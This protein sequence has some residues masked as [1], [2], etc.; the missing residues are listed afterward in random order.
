[1]IDDK[2]TLTKTNI[3]HENNI[4]NI[5]LDD[6]KDQCVFKDLGIYFGELTVKDLNCE[7]IEEYINYVEPKHKI[8]MSVFVNKHLIPY[9][10]K[11][12]SEL[13]YTK[14]QNQ[15][16]NCTFKDGVFDGSFA[17]RSHSIYNYKIDISKLKSAFLENVRV[18]SKVKSIE[19]SSNGLYSS[20]LPFILN[21]LKDPEITNCLQDTIINLSDNKIEGLGE[22][23]NIVD[24][25]IKSIAEIDSIKYIIMT[26]NPFA[27]I[28]RKDFFET[29]DIN[30]IITKKIIWIRDYNITVFGWQMLVQSKEV[31]DFVKNVH[32]EYYKKCKLEN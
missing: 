19:L 24:N 10:N 4:V 7:D 2:A 1:M 23:R 26:G 25:C 5:V 18:N 9:I 21:F 20:D 14:E 27:T 31:C 22:Y 17:F 13:F 29:L 12:S 32:Y 6:Q 8:L 3:V 30:N 28:S 11:L 15:I 16:K